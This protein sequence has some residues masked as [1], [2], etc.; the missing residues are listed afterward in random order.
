M[1]LVVDIGNTETVVGVYEETVLRAYWRLSSKLPRTSDECWTLIRSWCDAEDL[2]IAKFDGFI[3]SSV[4]PSLTAVFRDVAVRYIDVDPIVINSDTHT[5][6]RLLYDT[7]QTVGADRICNAV[8]AYALYNGPVIVV[9][10]GT[11]TTFDVISKNG[12]YLG[13]A[14]SLGVMGASHELHRLA[15]KLPRV[16]LEFPPAVVGKTTESSIQSGI[17]WGTVALVDGMIERI[18]KEMGW[19]SVEVVATGGMAPM[20]VDKSRRI[21]IVEPILTLEGMRMIFQGLTKP[22]KEGS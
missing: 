15:A 9:D 20:I 4:V 17:L 6:L 10:F 13:G 5:G 8:A 22:S 21:N 16:D 2:N 1:I 12:E 14:I 11:A 3:I 18:T 19:K 7:P